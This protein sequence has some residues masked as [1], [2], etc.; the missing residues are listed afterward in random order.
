MNEVVVKL[1]NSSIYCSSHCAGIADVVGDENLEVMV[2]QQSSS[3]G[4]IRII[5]ADGSTYKYENY[6]GIGTHTQAAIYDID[7][8]GNIELITSY[9]T[10]PKVWDL[11]DWTLDAT[12]SDVTCSGPP[13]FANVLG[14]SDMEI[15]A[16]TGSEVCRIYDNEYNI[17][18]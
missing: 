10:N 14:D 6:L 1:W 2:L 3:N 18:Y 13:D 11:V 15:I 16:C 4:G 8:D 7:N 5:N 12:L 9:N 17:F